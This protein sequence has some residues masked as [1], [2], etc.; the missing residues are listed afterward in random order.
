MTQ[1]KHSHSKRENE[2]IKGRVGKIKLNC[3]RAMI[4]VLHA[5]LLEPEISIC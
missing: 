4:A 1:Y 3:I 5:W 2:M